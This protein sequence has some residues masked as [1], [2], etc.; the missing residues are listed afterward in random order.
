MNNGQILDAI[1]MIND[2]AIADANACQRPKTNRWLKWGAM[3]ACVCLS[4]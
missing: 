4:V 1:G 2:E 3:A